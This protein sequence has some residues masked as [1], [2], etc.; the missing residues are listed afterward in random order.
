MRIRLYRVQIR[1]VNIAVQNHDI[2]KIVHVRAKIYPKQEKNVDS[3]QKLSKGKILKLMTQDDS[4]E[5]F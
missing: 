1:M 2:P 4:D 3:D 5:Y